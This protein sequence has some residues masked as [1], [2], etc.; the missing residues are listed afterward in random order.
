MNQSK[1]PA[2]VRS[3][4]MITDALLKLM[5]R[6][7]YC[8]I[9]VKQ[10]ILE[11]KV[12]RKTF[13]RNFED[14]DDVLKTYVDKNIY[15]YIQALMEKPE[16][17]LA[18]IFDFCE[19]KR[20]MLKLLDKNDMLHLLLQR[21]NEMIPEYSKNHDMSRNPF[22]QLFGEL[23]PEYLIA[24]NVGAIWN[25]IFKWVRRGMTDPPDEV[26]DILKSYVAQTVANQ[27]IIT[28]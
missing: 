19:Q 6:Y 12:A 1:N 11:A 5:E 21:L 8:E 14:K 9:S 4:Q 23:D 27:Q 18:V 22:A 16:D 2:S 17:P 26:R 13:Y 15:E 10:L 24:F 20:K 25:V 3:R 7:P 28:K